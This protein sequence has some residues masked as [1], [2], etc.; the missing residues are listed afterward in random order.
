MVRVRSATQSFMSN[1]I[2][3][4]FRSLTRGINS[5]TSGFVWAGVAIAALAALAWRTDSAGKPPKS[6]VLPEMTESV[7]MAPIGLPSPLASRDG[8]A[9][10][11]TPP[12]DLAEAILLEDAF[13]ALR[14]HESI[15]VAQLRG[16]LMERGSEEADT[17]D[18]A[19]LRSLLASDP[20]FRIVSRTS[21]QLAHRKSRK[22][23]AS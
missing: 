19:S 17:I 5:D 13:A 7:A 1:T 11:T 15:G 21:V 20:R 23:D 2:A 4:L 8:P 22:E 3:R 10:A 9:R 18:I 6:R 16:R 14:P 12:P